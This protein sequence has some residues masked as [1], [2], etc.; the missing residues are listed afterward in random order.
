[1]GFEGWKYTPRWRGFDRFYGYYSGS[2]GY[3]SKRKGVD[4]AVDL[5][6]DEEVVTD[7]R[8]L[9]THLTILLQQKANAT[10]E[11]HAAAHGAAEGAEGAEGRRT[12]LFLYYA[13]QNIHRDP[14]VGYVAPAEYVAL[15]SDEGDEQL[16][17]R[18]ALTVMLDEVVGQTVCKLHEVGMARQ[19][20]MVVASDNG[21]VAT[22]DGS[23]TPL[24]G[25]NGA[26]LEGG[27]RSTALVYSASAA[28]VPAAA[29]GSEYGGLVHVTDW[30]ATLLRLA[31]GLKLGL[32]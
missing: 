2:I 22:V 16:R 20:L 14:V 6:D 1:M 27:V 13:P 7:A 24:R 30:F 5:H 31:L 32:G 25:A 28:L 18:C 3:E 23:N 9:D 21:G 19:T 10:L 12:P 29:R 15:C 11:E 26:L 8:E 17:H 4:D